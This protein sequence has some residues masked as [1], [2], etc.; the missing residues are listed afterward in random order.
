MN[1][2]YKVLYRNKDNQYRTEGFRTADL[3]P[4]E[5]VAS[6]KRQGLNVV[7]WGFVCERKGGGCSCQY[8]GD[9]LGKGTYWTRS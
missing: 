4:E 6:L 3:A 1:H 7:G 8:L 5:A 9:I 2:I